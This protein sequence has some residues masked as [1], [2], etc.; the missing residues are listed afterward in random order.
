MSGVESFAALTVNDQL[1]LRADYT[2]TV[3][4]DETTEL[5]LLR[6]PGNK[7]SLTAIWTPNDRTTISATLLHVSSWVDVNRD[8]AKFIP[9]LDTPAYTTV[10]LAGSYD[11]NQNVTVFARADNLFNEQYQVPYRVPTARSWRLCRGAPAQLMALPGRK[12]AW[13]VANAGHAV[14]HESC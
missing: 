10:N 7:S 8:T 4:R 2:T 6:R 9:R 13:P 1:K 12:K 11:L 3:T 14:I 5:G